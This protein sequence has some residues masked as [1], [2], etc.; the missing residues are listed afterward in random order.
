MIRNQ[1]TYNIARQML[2][3]ARFL[4][5]TSRA[6]FTIRNYC[7]W[8]IS[9]TTHVLLVLSCRQGFLWISQKKQFLVAKCSLILYDIA[10]SC[11]LHLKEWGLKKPCVN[12]WSKWTQT[13]FLVR[14]RMVSQSEEQ[15]F[16]KPYQ[17]REI[18]QFSL[19]FSLL[20][21]PYFCQVNPWKQTYD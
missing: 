18:Q 3:N 8:L 21:S 13:C 16:V 4:R 17:Y 9:E 6:H 11:L 15:F 5:L 12:F 10:T 7:F 20:F 19:P 1:A 14:S 2:V